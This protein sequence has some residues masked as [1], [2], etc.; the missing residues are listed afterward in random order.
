M[1]INNATT[2][3][4]GV[5]ES[6]LKPAQ[7]LIC[8]YLRTHMNDYR[9]TAWPSVAR[10]A[11]KCSLS[12]RSVQGHLKAIC[13]AGYL[14]NN[15]HSQSGTIRYAICTPA[16]SAPPQKT[17]LPPAESAPELTKELTNNTYKGKFER[18]SIDEVAEYCRERGNQVDPEKFVNHY[19]S[20]G[21][22]VGK[23]SM[24]DWKAAVRTWEKNSYE[25]VGQ[26]NG[27][28]GKLSGAEKTRRAREAARA[29]EHSA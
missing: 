17:T 25:R 3:A 16:E 1:T 8:L 12:V 18:P 5:F 27:F 11:G 7:K 10:I 26:N 28:G 23:N 2:W 24:K 14:I 21:W 6:D 19:D 4:L 15:G 20:N 22:K 9:E 13:E 29:R